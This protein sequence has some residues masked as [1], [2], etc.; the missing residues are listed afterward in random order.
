M[1]AVLNGQRMLVKRYDSCR[2]HDA[3]NGRCVSFEQSRGWA[4]AGARF[5]VI[6]RET[7]VGM[8]SVPLA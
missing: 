2:L 1:S 6:E 3:S 7:G 5:D 8:R 4:A